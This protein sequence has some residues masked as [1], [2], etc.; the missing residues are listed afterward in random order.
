M[1]EQDYANAYCMAQSFV[2]GQISSEAA[3]LLPAGSPR[4]WW[5]SLEVAIAA[6]MVGI[7]MPHMAWWRRR[8]LRR[9]RPASCWELENRW[10][11]G[12]IHSVDRDAKLVPLLVD[13]A[14]QSWEMA[15]SEAQPKPGECFVI[16]R[17]A[18]DAE[19]V[20][21]LLGLIRGMANE[22]LLAA[23][24]RNLKVWD[25]A[26]CEYNWKLPE[27]QLEAPQHIVF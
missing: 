24:A 5:A 27:L 12:R 3:K 26:V 2:D 18:S 10:F 14:R 20:S 7:S 16:S 25:R 8:D 21:E 13:S 1:I 9:E 23:T 17:S 15:K 11:P 4:V 22:V 6:A 19:V